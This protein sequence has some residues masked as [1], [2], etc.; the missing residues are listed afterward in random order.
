M[1]RWFQNERG[2]CPKPGRKPGSYWLCFRSGKRYKPVY[3]EAIGRGLFSSEWEWNLQGIPTDIIA[4]GVI[5]TTPP[6]EKR[7]EAG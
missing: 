6:D 7:A 5:A 4:I 1:I 2:V 3:S